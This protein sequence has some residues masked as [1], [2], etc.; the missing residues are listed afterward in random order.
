MTGK[1]LE[2]KKRGRDLYPHHRLSDKPIEKFPVST[3]QSNNELFQETAE[4]LIDEWKKNA[5]KNCLNEFV[6]SKIPEY[7]KS[8]KSADYVND[9]NVISS[10]EQKLKI[11]VSVFYPGCTAHNPY[12]WLASFHNGIEV[13]T[14]PTDM[15]SEANARALNIIFYLSFMAKLKKIGRD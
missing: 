15:A 13:F 5:V 7:A 4:Y 3:I 12:G 6:A 14:T 8:V 1:I 2:F 10:V 9:L 11:T